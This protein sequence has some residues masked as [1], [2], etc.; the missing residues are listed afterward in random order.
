MKFLLLSC[1]LLLSLPVGADPEP[2]RAISVEQV[3]RAN[4][5]DVY[6]QNVEPCDITVTFDVITERARVDHPV[7]CT[8]T[9]GPH[10]RVRAFGITSTGSAWHFNYKDAWVWGTTDARPDPNAAYRL[11]FPTGMSCRVTQG[12]HGQMDHNGDQAYAVDFQMPIATPVCAARAGQVVLTV[13]NY[14]GVGTDPSFL[15]RVNQVLVKHSDGTYGQYLHLKPGGIR[16]HPGDSVTAGQVLALSGNTGYST[17]PHL[18]FI[19]F[20]AQ[21]GYHRES[22]PFQFDVAGQD[23]PVTPERGSTYTA[24]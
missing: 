13:D 24:R 11:P 9:V 21:D 4:G 3:K 22:F 18:H 20:R 10:A 14:T 16:V 23:R 8:L 15:Q 2:I 7:P 6:V 17:G 1:L 5:V 12:F 19:V